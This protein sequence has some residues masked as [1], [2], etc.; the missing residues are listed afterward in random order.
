MDVVV[1]SRIV[2]D[3]PVLDS[4]VVGSTVVD[5]VEEVDNAVVSV[6]AIEYIQKI[7]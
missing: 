4:P 1:D 2:L 6:G 5:S 3:R 7:F